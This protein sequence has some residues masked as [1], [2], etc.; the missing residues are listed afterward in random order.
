MNKNQS[1]F[2]LRCSRGTEVFPSIPITRNNRKFLFSQYI[3]ACNVSGSHFFCTH[4]YDAIL[5]LISHCYFI[6][7]LKI[8]HQSWASFSFRFFFLLINSRFTYEKKHNRRWYAVCFFLI[9]VHNQSVERANGSVNLESSDFSQSAFSWWSHNAQKID[10]TEQVSMVDF[11]WTP[12]RICSC[13]DVGVY[14]LKRSYCKAAPINPIYPM[15]NC[16]LN[17]THSIVSQVRS[18]Q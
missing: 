6:T 1:K 9:Y 17:A 11:R 5:T 7:S 2:K 8:S 4:L 3:S 18:N 10:V 16:S 14:R 15:T 13:A 12:C